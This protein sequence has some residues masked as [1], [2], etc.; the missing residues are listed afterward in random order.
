M[1]T[2]ILFVNFNSNP[3]MTVTDS[4]TGVVYIP[5]KPI[6]EA[7]GID[8]KG[9]YEKIKQDDV[10]SS[11]MEGIT[12]T[13]SDGKGYKTVCLPLDYIN[14]WLFKLN[15]SKIRNPI[16]KQKVIFM[17]KYLYQQIKHI[18]ESYDQ[19][20]YALETFE[21]D[22]SV[23]DATDYQLFVYAIQESET[24]RIK[25]GISESPERRLKELQTGNSQELILLGYVPANGGFNDEKRLHSDC[26]NYHIR[27]EW[28]KQDVLS[29]LL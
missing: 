29:K 25:L 14:G 12:V 19:I 3:I 20:I 15:P 4:Q 23:I 9:Q 1:P 7:I 5:C 16:T 17:Q 6:C 13:A 2:E 27:G 10:L 8:W 22:Q 24:K 18:F 21:I 26:V 28:Y 11:V